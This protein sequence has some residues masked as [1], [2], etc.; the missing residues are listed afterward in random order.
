LDITLEKKNPTE[1]SIKITLTEAD[2]QPKVRE[3]LKEYSK[4][5]QIKGFRPG[6]VPP[7]LIQKM[8][9]KSIMIDEINHIL[10]HAVNDYIR[11]N[12]I[13]ILGDP[14][15]N[16]ENADKIDWENQKDFEFQYEIG[17]VDDFKYALEGKKLIR[18]NIKVD[19]K[20]VEDTI[21][22][23]QKQYGKM[24]N[25]EKSEDG[26]FL[27]GQ[28]VQN[29]GE[30]NDKVSIPLNLIEKK[31][32]KNFIGLSKGDKV[33]FDVKKAFKDAATI[34][35]ALNI[36]GAAAEALE[37]EFEL[38]VINV[39]RQEAAELD[40]EFFDK[41][42]GPEVVK[43]EEEFRNKVKETISENYKRETEIY[44][45]RTIQDALLE[46]TEI[47]LPDEFLKRWLLTTNE[48]KITEEDIAK[49]YDAYAKEMKWT[50]IQNKIG[51]DHE[52]KVENSDIEE[53]AKQIISDQ[54][55]S[56]GLLAQLGDNL[57]AFVQNYLQSNNG[58]NYMRV[59][60]QVK[61]EKVFEIVREKAEIEE[62]EVDVEE[63]KDIV[64]KK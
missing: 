44:F 48:G 62:K 3:K 35:D 7:A 29:G 18:Y 60:S 20:S 28:V 57:D 36:D 54:L 31:E 49:E 55:G 19:D 58:D 42:F 13:K 12:K 11:D 59:F 52:I 37:G 26:D 10:S 46:S 64:T 38:E 32:R 51:E 14:L 63:F 40:Q 25:P 4:K 33:T 47:T 27:Y 34:A 30:F 6:K 17:L 53:K 15:P 8:Y 61:A 39:N 16:T 9:G 24:T 22:D 45:D 5:A 2:Y 21:A 50:L 43:S 1:A 41:I 56:S 23:L